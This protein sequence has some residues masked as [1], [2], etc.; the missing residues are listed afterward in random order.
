M[1]LITPI[2]ADISGV[3]PGGL[4]VYYDSPA[5]SGHW[6]AIVHNRVDEPATTNIDRVNAPISDIQLVARALSSASSAK[7]AMRTQ[8]AI[9]QPSAFL[10][11]TLA[12]GADLSRF[13]RQFDPAVGG[14]FSSVYFPL[15]GLSWL[16]SPGISPLT[17]DQCGTA[18][19]LSTVGDANQGGWRQ[20]HPPREGADQIFS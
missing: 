10:S 2:C 20:I 4:Y 18:I 17:R 19:G 5:I 3:L 7:P 1:E 8:V 16:C 14:G 13:F 9:K 15:F 11:F 12:A 6:R